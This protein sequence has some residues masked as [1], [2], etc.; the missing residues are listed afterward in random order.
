MPFSCCAGVG[1]ADRAGDGA[2][3][4]CVESVLLPLD[5]SP[6]RGGEGTGT[7][8]G[9]G[10]G[11]RADMDPCSWLPPLWGARAAGGAGAVGGTGAGAVAEAASRCN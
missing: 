2:Q 3:V 8:A 6:R 1:G 9:N 11:S 4:P 7:G 5:G 10:A